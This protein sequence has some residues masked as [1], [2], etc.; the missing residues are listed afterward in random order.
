[1]GPFR[2]RHESTDGADRSNRSPVAE[3]AD[4]LARDQGYMSAAHKAGSEAGKRARAARTPAD[5]NA[6]AKSVGSVSGAE[7]LTSEQEAAALNPGPGGLPDARLQRVRDRLLVVTSA[8]WVNPKSRTAYRYGLHSFQLRGTNHY[9]AALKSGRFTPGAP[10]RL[11]READNGHDPNAVAVYAQSGRDRA[12]YVPASQA[13]RL[14]P[15]M[16]SG[17]EFAAVS[18]RGAGSGRDGTVPHIL[19]CERSLFDHLTRP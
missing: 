17:V 16:D 2:R 15:M 13:R 14:A 19:V 4:A 8:G 10:V 6:R 7:Y 9:A 5:S 18:T 11:V 3:D 1:M 12:G